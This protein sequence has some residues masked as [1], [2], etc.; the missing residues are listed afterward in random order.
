MNDRDRADVAGGP[1]AK[2]NAICADCR[3]PFVKGAADTGWLCDRCIS[4]Q[5]F[6]RVERTR[7]A[8][9]TPVPSQ[10]KVS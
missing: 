6:E 5:D 10:R 4:Q 2:Y 9:R 3:A 7:T 8:T 1:Y